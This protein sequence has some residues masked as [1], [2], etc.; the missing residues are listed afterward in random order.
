M[1]HEAAKLESF[2]LT[3]SIASKIWKTIFNI[4]KKNHMI[5]SRD[6]KEANWNPC[7]NFRVVEKF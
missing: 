5:F 6:K 7:Q 2:Q 1:L 4:I 3:E